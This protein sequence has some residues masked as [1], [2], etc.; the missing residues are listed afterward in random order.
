MLVSLEM[1]A[2]SP[3]EPWHVPVSW[4]RDY[5]AGRVFYT[6]FGHNDVTWKDPM[7]QEHIAEGIA[8]SLK[9]FD[10]EATPNPDVQAAE[11]L[12]SVIAA[13]AAAT[14]KFRRPAG[15]GRRESRPRSI[16]GDRP[17]SAA[18]RTP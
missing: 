10:A 9:R 17:A 8:W 11:Y 14:G 1:Q 12:R 6:N 18:F 3:R 13:A 5:G 16:V 4:V 2:S 15:E 7:F